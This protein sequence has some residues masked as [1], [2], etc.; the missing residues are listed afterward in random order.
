MPGID[1][2]QDPELIERLAAEYALGTLRGLAR[3]RFERLA[4]ERPYVRE[5][6]DAWARRLAPL[7]RAVAEVTPPARVWHGIE[8]EVRAERA[9]AERAART[10]WWQKLVAWRM[11]TAVSVL[12]ALAV[13]WY[14]THR[15]ESVVQEAPEYVVVLK[16]E[17]QEPMAV[18]AGMR[19]PMRI[20]VNLRKE[21]RM[22]KDRV[23]VLW[24][25][26]KGT[27][28]VPMGV[29]DRR[30]KVIPLDQE[31]WDALGKAQGFAVSLEP[32]ERPLRGGGPKGP[33]MYEGELV[34]L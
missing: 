26:M 32:P 22:P 3:V 29:L 20:A 15:I 4:Q 25:L 8:A 34:A 23:M 10:R 19:N 7:A 30:E 11:A 14:S 31:S 28:P 5:A 16:N 17:A 12:L 2:Y 27:K 9:L 6:A 1:R 13:T 24:C 33:V 21:V 18:V